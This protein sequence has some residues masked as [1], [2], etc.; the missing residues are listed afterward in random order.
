M[1]NVLDILKRVVNESLAT[2]VYELP[3]K[4]Y[5]SPNVGNNDAGATGLGGS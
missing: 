3:R 1:L 5:E 2:R 4:S